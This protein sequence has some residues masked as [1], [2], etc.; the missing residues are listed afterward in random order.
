[1]SR[2]TSN[3]TNSELRR[4]FEVGDVPS[5]LYEHIRKTTNDYLSLY[6][7]GRTWSNISN[8]IKREILLLWKKFVDK[9][10]SNRSDM[11]EINERSQINNYQLPPRGLIS[12]SYGG[13]GALER[14]LL[15]WNREECNKLMNILEY[16]E[17]MRAGGG[18]GI[19]KRVKKYKSKNK[20]SKKRKSKKRKS[21]KRKSK[22][23]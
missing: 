21:K 7:E 23:R 17:S 13:E 3:L 5:P 10:G 14:E 16:E 11:N 9:Y 1:M 19:K 2:M 8:N 15:R 12:Q 22:K 18:V 4:L 20:R 6:H